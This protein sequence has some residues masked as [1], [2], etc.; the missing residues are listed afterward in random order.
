M[1][2]KAASCFSCLLL[3]LLDST[4]AAV[5][6][7]RS[8]IADHGLGQLAKRKEQQQHEPGTGAAKKEQPSELHSTHRLNTISAHKTP[9]VNESDTLD[10]RQRRH[11]QPGGGQAAAPALP[12]ATNNSQS[13]LLQLQQPRCLGT[14]GSWCQEFLSQEPIPWKVGNTAAADPADHECHAA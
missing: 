13:Q 4:G 12:G 1:V 7:Q 9:Q 10:R 6:Q 3:L 14:T 11:S 5:E 2:R 8:E